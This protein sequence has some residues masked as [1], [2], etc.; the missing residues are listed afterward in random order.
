VRAN[1]VIICEG[2][3]DVIAFAEVGLARAVATC[4]TALTDDH[5]RTLQRFAPKLVLAF[6]P[7]AAGQAAAD[8]V[9][10]WERKHEVEVAVAVL[11]AGGDP[12][13]LAREDP[14][15]LR[16]A[17]ES[18]QPFLGFRVD[19]ILAAAN[20]RT[21]EGR[22]RAA[23]AALEAIAEHPSEFV[24]D[25][26]VMTVAGQCQLDPDR[27]RSSLRAGGG[28][29]RVRVETPRARPV[30]ADTPETEAL[31]LAVAH[32]AEVLPQLHEVLFDDER[33][34]AAFRALAAA[35][36]DLHAAVADA[37]PLVE[38]HLSRLAV[39][40]TDADV[41]DVRRML[42]R[43]LAQR[44]IAEIEGA[45][46]SSDDFAARAQL[47]GWL[48]TRI[49]AIAPDAPPDPTGEDE[50]LGWLAQRVEGRR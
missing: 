36:G 4:G 26:Y 33:N 12:A 20:L 21:P 11:P 23:E 9:Y 2:Y 34:Q 27:L 24:R 28:R 38:E 47:V 50:L 48:K 17:V 25:Q 8:R 7:D 1:E 49:E 22:G 37:D 41:I 44:E 18:A 5:V 42:L 29:P 19:R 31:R 6:D 30:R 43:D 13:E 46:S 3:T 45:V 16:K 14:E 40:D 35:G 10:E 32:P 15:G 39:E